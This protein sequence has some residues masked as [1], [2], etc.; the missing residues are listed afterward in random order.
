MSLTVLHVL[1]AVGHGTGR[2]LVDLVD[3]VPDVR[4][5]VV[6][7]ESPTPRGETSTSSTATSLAERGITVHRVPMRRT[8][9]HPDLAV[10]VRRTRRLVQSE[11]VDVVHGHATVGGVVARLAAIGTRTPAVYTP[12]GLHPSAL[13]VAAERALAW[14]TRRF[15]AVSASEADDLVRRLGV[16]RDRIVVVPNGIDL[17]APPAAAD[18]RTE[19]GLAPTTSLIGWVGR[20]SR[21][22]APDV[23]VAAAVAVPDDV[24]VVLV[25]GGPQAADVAAQVGRLGLRDRVHLLGHR[26]RAAALIP[27]F[28]VVALPSRWEGAPYVPLEAFRAG[29]PVVVSDVTGSRDTVTHDVDGLVVPPDDVEALAA[30]LNRVLADRDLAA[31]LATAGHETLWARFDVRAMGASLAHAYR[32]LPVSSGSGR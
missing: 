26:P 25:G 31:R 8:P 3:H 17:T 21:Q 22:K 2:H 5:V 10:A 27:Q 12:N 19:L 4:H 15:V 20:L 6:L 24:H 29:T 9:L 1:E 30:A 23:L 16:A 18:L 14:R 13:V 32:N 11:E 7:P 28:D